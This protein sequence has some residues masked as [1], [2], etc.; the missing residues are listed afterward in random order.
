MR[1]PICWSADTTKDDIAL[2]K[3]TT[4][5]TGKPKAAVHCQHDPVISF[6]GYA[7]QVL[8]MTQ[9]DRILAVP[10]L[11]FGYARDL[12]TLF[13]YGVGACGIIFPERSTPERM[14]TL[15]EQHKPTILVNV[16]TMM[17][18][19]I[20]HPDATKYDVSSLRLNTSAGEALSP[21][22][23][24]SWLDTFGV[25]TINGIGSSEAYHIYISGSS[26]LRRDVSGSLGQVVP[27]YSSRDR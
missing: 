24:Q 20:N 27:C 8:N 11:F 21:V 26:W 1:P 16:P 12:V 17:N 6:V 13:A 7:Q 10:K 2:W 18:A 15:V 9:S 19:M 4:G 23:H 25:E 14:L 3:F 5:S 22:I